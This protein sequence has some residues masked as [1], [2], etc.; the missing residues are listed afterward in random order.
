MARPTVSDREEP[1]GFL[2]RRK[3]GKAVQHLL[4]EAR[5]ARLMREDIA[6]PAALAALAAAEKALQD[7][8]AGGGRA[9]LDRAAETLT[10]ATHAVYP[11]HR[12]PRLR[13]N[14]EI[15]VVA[16]AVAMAFRTFFIQPFRIPTG[17]MQPTLYGITYGDQPVARWMDRFPLSLGSFLL[18]GESYKA[19]KAKADGRVEFLNESTEEFH[20]LR[21]AGVPHLVPRDMP[22]R[23]DVGRATVN[24]GD[25]LASG[26]KRLGDHIFVNRLAY[27]FRPP[28]RGDIFVF[29]TEAIRHPAIRPDNYYI[30]RLVGLPRETIAID[31]P[32]LL[33]DGERVESPP[34][35]L[36][37][38]TADGYDGYIP[39][40]MSGIPSV[41]RTTRDRVQ[42]AEDEYLPMGDNTKSSLDGRYFGAVQRD[43]IVGPA[44]MVYWPFSHRWGLVE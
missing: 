27:N 23:V 9:H 33:V 3:T 34:A 14:I 11:P 29:S 8:W 41:L 40:G 1:M 26:R 43:S 32:W 35:F 21:V 18:F 17:S 30:K 6:Q 25:V 31:P 42:L 20:V 38:A 36:R 15:L 5:H 13:E 19:I 10:E 7:A 12:K 16:L 39:V 37:Q 44:F 22:V 28:R 4:H 2:E 24:K